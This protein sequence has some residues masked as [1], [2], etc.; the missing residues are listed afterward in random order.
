MMSFRVTPGN[1][2]EQVSRRVDVELCETAVDWPGIPIAVPIGIVG[3][4][5]N[6][7]KAARDG[8]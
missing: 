6:Q 7:G 3:T 8:D 5:A 4:D 2:D 1:R